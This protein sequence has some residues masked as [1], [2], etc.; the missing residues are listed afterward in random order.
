MANPN[1]VQTSSIQGQTN[2]QTATTS[3]AAIVDN[4]SASGE[5]FKLNLLM[6]HN[7]TNSDATMSVLFNTFE[8]ISDLTIPANS[9]IN[10]LDKSLYIREG[11]YV[12]IQ[13]SANSTIN[14]IASFERIS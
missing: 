6:A 10:I 8:F 5:V 4:T 14:V 7:K 2:T 1:I 13:A 3:A 12:A 9:T 11:E